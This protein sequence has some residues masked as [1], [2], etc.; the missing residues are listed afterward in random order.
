M[1]RWAWQLDT[2]VFSRDNLLG[3]LKPITNSLTDI[4]DDPLEFDKL[5]IRT[6]MGASLI[7][8]IRGEKGA[9]RGNDLI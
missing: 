2:D 3:A 7:P 5:A 6:K 1:G 4:F 9:V 8:R